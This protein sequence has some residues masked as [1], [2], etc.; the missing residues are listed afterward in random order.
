[1]DAGCMAFELKAGGFGVPT[2]TPSARQIRPRPRCTQ[3]KDSKGVR[4]VL[5][6]SAEFERRRNMRGETRSGKANTVRML[7]VTQA[8]SSVAV[9]S[10][11]PAST[12]LDISS[13][14]DGGALLSPNDCISK[15]FA[16][17]T[18]KVSSF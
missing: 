15:E 11:L 3:R 1:M 17:D 9:L 13:G 16:A 2:T 6:S 14:A 5:A 8:Q 18:M 7:A 10:T 4:I 12:V